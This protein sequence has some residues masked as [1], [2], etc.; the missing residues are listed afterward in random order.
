MVPKELGPGRSIRPL[1][2]NRL[3]A[4]FDRLRLDEDDPRFSWRR[5]SLRDPS[6]RGSRR[7]ASWTQ[8]A[9]PSFE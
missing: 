5:F 3:R 1:A 8:Q 4:Y 6:P 9:T 7:A 2:V